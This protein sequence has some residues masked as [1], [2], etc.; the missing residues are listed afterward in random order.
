MGEYA[1]I[2]VDSGEHIVDKDES[3]A[4]ER[5]QETFGQRLFY[6]VQIGNLK[7]PTINFRERKN[8]AWIFAQ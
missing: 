8:V 3:R 6:I 1:A 7:E 2:D 4:I 5:A